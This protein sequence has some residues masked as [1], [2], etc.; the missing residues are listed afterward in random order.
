MI[1]RIKKRLYLGVAAY[2]RF[3][4]NLSLR[5]WNPRVIAVTGS[6]GKTTML[7]LVELQLRDKAHYSHDAN[8]A[9][10]IAFD[11]VGLKGVTDS[12]LR[13]LYLFIAVPVK[14]LYFKH[15]EEFYVVEIDGER[16]KETEF[17]AKWL[18]P[19]VTV[20]VSLGRSHASYYDEQVRRGMFDNVDEAIAHEF[21]YLPRLTSKI[22]IAEG[23]NELINKQL[24][25]ISAKV[26][27][28]HMNDLLDY[29]VTPEKTYFRLNSA[30]VE[31]SC[32][33][34]R[35]VATQLLL[36]EKL[37]EYLGIKLV[38]DLR[39]YVPAPGRNSLVMGRRGVQMIDSSYNAHLISMKS[40]FDM[41][42]RMTADK[43]WLV[44]GDMTEQ[45]DGEEDQHRQLGREMSKVEADRYV[46]VGRRTGKYTLPELIEA[47]LEEKTVSFAKATDALEYLD[48][49]LA[50]GET[51]L[52][53]GSQYLEWII[54]KLL[55]NP[56][57]VKLLPRQEPSAKRRRAE[58]GL[59]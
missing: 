25:G 39:E 9:F 29:R 4:S 47:G 2:F 51:V 33:M 46:L 48:N 55:E 20:W 30:E 52:F 58:W 15:Q 26:Q 24:I 59:K 22:V 13:W 41:F 45:G 37:A 32:P 34:P 31:F 42:E 8:S 57:D 16:P 49:E 11:I 5:R 23:D 28:V 35:E 17:L 3:W 54:E 6:V 18:K 53:K 43:K 27:K 50:G 10:G 44:I 7:R 14:S 38:T 40:M 19:E 12:K 56:E 36:L 21:G 1:A